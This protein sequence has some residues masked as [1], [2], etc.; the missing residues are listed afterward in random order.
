MKR[1]ATDD[2]R[3]GIPLA[4]Y[5]TLWLWRPIQFMFGGIMFGMFAGACTCA[6]LLRVAQ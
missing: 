3:A 1:R 4:E 6:I 5:N 2:F